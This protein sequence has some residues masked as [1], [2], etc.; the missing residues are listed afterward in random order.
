MHII[1]ELHP[2][3]ILAACGA[4]RAWEHNLAGERRFKMQHFPSLFFKKRSIKEEIRD[5]GVE[6]Q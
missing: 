6:G 3:V 4:Q 5:G 1:N 2:K